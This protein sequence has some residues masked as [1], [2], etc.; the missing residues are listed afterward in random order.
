M[1]VQKEGEINAQN[2]KIKIKLFEIRAKNDIVHQK[3][4][5]NAN[6]GTTTATNKRKN[7]LLFQLFLSM[8]QTISSVHSLFWSVNKMIA[9]SIAILVFYSKYYY[10][11]R[12]WTPKQ[13]VF[14][15][16][17]FLLQ[18][19]WSFKDWSYEFCV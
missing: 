5:K 17:N 2:K 3:P 13:I 16:E 9:F 10:T 7:T 6:R 1:E 15:I 14:I 11:A 12:A 18:F 19:T 8:E 4:S